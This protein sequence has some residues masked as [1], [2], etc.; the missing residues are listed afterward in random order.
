[1]P[2]ACLPLLLSVSRFLLFLCS[3]VA[4]VLDMFWIG[5]SSMCFPRSVYVSFSI[6]LYQYWYWYW[7]PISF[8][9]RIVF[10]PHR[11]PTPSCSLFPHSADAGYL[12]IHIYRY[13]LNHGL[14]TLSRTYIQRKGY[15]FKLDIFTDCG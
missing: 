9:L 1:M 6:V 3:S 11:I 13:Y 7:Y 15:Y 8:L 10:I 14:H 2:T 5:L 12:F 4:Y